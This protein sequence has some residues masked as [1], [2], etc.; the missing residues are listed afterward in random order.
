MLFTENTST[1]SGTE[2]MKVKGWERVYWGNI[3]WKKYDESILS[4]KID[5]GVKST[6]GDRENQ[7]IMIKQFI[8]SSR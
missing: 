5:L 1:L 8:S 7:Y 2:K 4:K 3:N 6:T